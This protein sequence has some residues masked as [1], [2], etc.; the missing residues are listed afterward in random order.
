M[1]VFD[2]TKWKLWEKMQ[3]EA[4]AVKR[5]GFIVL[6]WKKLVCLSFLKSVSAEKYK[7]R[8]INISVN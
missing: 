7:S 3:S 1:K 4:V 8:N 6:K 5:S 2:S